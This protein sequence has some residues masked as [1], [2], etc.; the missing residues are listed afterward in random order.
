MTVRSVGLVAL[1]SSPL[2]ALGEGKAGGMSAYVLGLGRELARRGI[3]VTVFTANH[4]GA[5]PVEAEYDGICGFS[6]CLRE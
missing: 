4:D 5:H 1:H 3:S 2:A 6:T